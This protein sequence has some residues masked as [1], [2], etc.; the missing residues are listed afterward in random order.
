[1]LPAK[2]AIFP[3]SHPLPRH[4]CGQRVSCIRELVQPIINF[5]L[6]PQFNSGSFRPLPVSHRHQ[7]GTGAGGGAGAGRRA[8]GKRRALLLGSGAGLHHL[9]ASVGMCL[10][11]FTH[12]QNKGKE[13]ALLNHTGDFPLL[14]LGGHGCWWSS[15][16]GRC[17]CTAQAQPA[18]NTWPCGHFLQSALLRLPLL[19]FTL[20]GC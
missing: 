4:L 6:S 12:R 10:Q 7:A 18:R 15:R 9:K 11:T 2:K 1:M 13:G 5:F 8:P 3:P 19:C 17:E 16:V 20:P 14:G